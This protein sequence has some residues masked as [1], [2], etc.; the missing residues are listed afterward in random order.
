VTS[1]HP[2]VRAGTGVVVPGSIA[3]LGPAFDVL[4]VAV[5]L[6]IRL[7]VR[8][9]LPS[10]PGLLDFDFGGCPPPGE[11]RIEV[12]FRR[13]AERF[14]RDAPGLRV[15]VRSDIPARA[16]LGS[17]AA[18]T[19]AGLRLYEAVTHPPARLEPPALRQ[20]S[21]Q[22]TERWLRVA[23]EIEGHPDNAAASL[24]GGLTLSCQRDD[25]TVIARSWPW[26]PALRFVVAT[27][28]L[29]LETRLARSV[30]PSALPMKDAI[31]NLQ[32]TA[33]LLHAV[34]S[35]GYE[36]LR[37]AMADRWHQPSRAPLVP[38]LAEALR[39]EHPSILGV[40]LSGAGPSIVALS[41]GGESEITPMFRDLYDR[42]GIACTI[43]TLSAHQPD[44]EFELL[45]P[46]TL[47]PSNL[48]T[49]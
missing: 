6:Y 39:L 17:S 3:N 28:D 26:P 31:F 21:L 22:A 41:A 32:R 20:A 29:P 4:S 1:V 30:L 36:D 18:A 34:Q 37:E 27:P 45:N 7:E 49:P 43:R 14:G 48:R 25:G 10:Q 8:E 15:A 12:A 38:G 19:V 13:A 46:R 9:V 5:Q 35:G 42:L 2:P 16:G 11:N 24:L 47:E 40:S 23:C 44:R 33:L